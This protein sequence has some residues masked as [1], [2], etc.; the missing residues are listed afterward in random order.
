MALATA[1]G[2]RPDSSGARTRCKFL[3]ANPYGLESFRGQLAKIRDLERTL[4]RLSSGSGNARDLVVLRLA[5][6][7]IPGLKE[8]LDRLE[9]P[10]APK[11]LD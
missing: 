7:Q 6:A 8:T 9:L 5:L 10:V 11:S 4:G 1:G 2:R 3:V